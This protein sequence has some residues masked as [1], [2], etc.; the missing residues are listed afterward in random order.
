M[1]PFRRRAALALILLAATGW[2][3]AATAQEIRWDIYY[4]LHTAFRGAEEPLAVVNGGV[5]DQ[6]A[7]L[8]P[9]AEVQSQFWRIAVAGDGFVRITSMFT[10]PWV[11]LDVITEGG[12]LKDG[13]E[14]RACTGSPTQSWKIEPDEGR[15]RLR[16]AALGREVCLEAI[17]G[18]G[19]DGLAAMRPC[20]FWGTQFWVLEPTGHVAQ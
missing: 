8:A 14:M 17:T 13:A 19:E 3:A 11:C 5:R 10:G 2:G 9:R 12:F 20:G 6:A 15:F 1:P 18:G 7:R 16:N 4:R